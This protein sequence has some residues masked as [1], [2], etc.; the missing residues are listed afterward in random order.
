MKTDN[1]ETRSR[2][3][4]YKGKGKKKEK[5]GTTSAISIETTKSQRQKLLRL[6]SKKNMTADQEFY[7]CYKDSLWG[8]SN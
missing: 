3:F 7:T 1:D 8:Y 6:P 4:E 5:G 2:I